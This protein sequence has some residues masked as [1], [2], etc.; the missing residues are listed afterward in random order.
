MNSRFHHQTIKN[1]LKLRQTVLGAAAGPG[2]AIRGPSEGPSAASPFKPGWREAPESR[3][4][5]LQPPQKSLCPRDATGRHPH[6]GRAAL[7]ERGLRRTNP[8]ATHRAPAGLLGAPRAGPPR[9]DAESLPV[10]RTPGGWC[11][12]IGQD[13]VPQSRP[14]PSRRGGP[15][16]RTGRC[17]R[18]RRRFAIVPPTE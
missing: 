7:A 12:P 4:L 14:A 11:R 5:Q 18:R 17:H 3:R 6:P 9:A 8:P 2:A 15:S 13:P 10:P 1:L 16:G